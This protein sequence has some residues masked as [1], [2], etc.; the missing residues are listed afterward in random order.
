MVGGE[1]GRLSPKAEDPGSIL[2]RRL[3]RDEGV[4]PVRSAVSGNNRFN[5]II[6]E[7]ANW[8]P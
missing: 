1:G 7:E 2:F 4:K 8:W 5:N 3:V 6:R